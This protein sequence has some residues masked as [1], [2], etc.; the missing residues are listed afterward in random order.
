MNLLYIYIKRLIDIILS[1][2]GIILLS[3]IFLIIALLIKIDSQ[4]NVFFKQKRV[5]KNKTHFNILK[6]RTM[7]SETPSDMPTH[8]LGNATSHIT[9]IGNFLRKSSLD[10]L[11][12]L[13]NIFKGDMSIVGPRP[14]LWNQYD[15]LTERDKFNANDVYPGLTGLAQISGR[16]E[17]SI[18]I[19][20]ELDGDY[21]L[22]MGFWMDI[23]CI[24][25]TVRSVLKRD[26]IVEG[27]SK[28][29]K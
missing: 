24:L 16:D 28:D 2:L 15:L 6:F 18:Y 17:L 27:D 23:K 22:N 25:G 3:P 10:E 20:A 19:K 5:G 9:N 4:G 21:V 12:Q 14:A 26:G 7:K 8:L 13:I 29:R 11:P 1:G